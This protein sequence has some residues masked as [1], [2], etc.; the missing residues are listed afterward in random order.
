MEWREFS[1]K[2]RQDTFNESFWGK[3][4]EYITFRNARDETDQ[5]FKDLQSL[6]QELE[7][8]GPLDQPTLSVLRKYGVNLSDLDTRVKQ[9][10]E[11]CL[12]SLKEIEIPVGRLLGELANP[13]RTLRMTYGESLAGLYDVY[14]K[15]KSDQA[16]TLSFTLQKIGGTPRFNELVKQYELEAAKNRVAEEPDS[17]EEK[18]E[19]QPVEESQQP[20]PVVTEVAADDAAPALPLANEVQQPPA[21]AVPKA[22]KASPPSGAKKKKN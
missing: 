6:I 8:L 21:A 18:V 4:D 1:E 22:P 19:M 9:V 17:D 2:N 13:L 7:S 11:T 5:N 20:P 16:S 12:P 10:F 3:I 15:T 14:N